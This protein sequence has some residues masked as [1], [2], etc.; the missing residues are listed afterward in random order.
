M[1]FP[2]VI[3]HVPGVRKEKAFRFT[4]PLVSR[5]MSNHHHKAL[6]DVPRPCLVSRLLIR[7]S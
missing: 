1:I 6:I 3:S 2:A 4:A 5:V 7:A